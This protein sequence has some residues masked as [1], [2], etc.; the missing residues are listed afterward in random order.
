MEPCLGCRI[1]Q[2]KNASCVN[3]L[4]ESFR[5]K[6]LLIIRDSCFSEGWYHDYSKTSRSPHK[7]NHFKCYYL[8]SSRIGNYSQTTGSGSEF[9]NLML[10][11]VFPHRKNG[12]TFADSWLDSVLRGEEKNLL[13]WTGV[14]GNQNEYVCNFSKV[15]NNQ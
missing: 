14:I 1:S 8:C 12:C 3:C 13:Y 11:E 7:E 5:G 10:N 4:V 2:E 15:K 9:T 6:R